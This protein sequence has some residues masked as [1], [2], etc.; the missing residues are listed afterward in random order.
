[1]QE[2]VIEVPRYLIIPPPISHGRGNS[3]QL[4]ESSI[5]AGDCLLSEESSKGDL[6]CKEE[7]LLPAN[8]SSSVLS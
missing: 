1:M 8:S 6:V 7:A 4:A 3:A 5:D 2:V